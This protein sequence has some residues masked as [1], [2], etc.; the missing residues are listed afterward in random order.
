M[1][2][3]AGE[4]MPVAC[5]SPSPPLSPAC[6]SYSRATTDR[7]KK[8]IYDALALLCGEQF[9]EPL[10]A[11]SYHRYVSPPDSAILDPV[12]SIAPLF[13][14]MAITYPQDTPLRGC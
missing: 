9:V 14:A 10:P 13:S 7:Y 11:T 1:L 8:T 3:R 6:L 2:A 4:R 5:T 12:P